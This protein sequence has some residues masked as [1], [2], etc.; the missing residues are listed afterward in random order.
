MIHD[1]T[2]QYFIGGR[3]RKSAAGEDGG[4]HISIKAFHLAA[5]LGESCHNAPNESHC[6]IDFLGLGNQV[7]DIHLTPGIAFGENPNHKGA[8]GT[9]GCN[10]I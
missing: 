4:G 2:D 8:V 3:G 5:H 10:G 7:G 6:G 1:G 9:D